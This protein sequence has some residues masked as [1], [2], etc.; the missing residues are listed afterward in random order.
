[1]GGL[2]DI[3]L[4]VNDRY[5]PTRSHRANPGRSTIQRED[6][7]GPE[8]YVGPITDR[9]LS[10]GP[11]PEPTDITLENFGRPIPEA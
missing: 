8:A 10:N 4:L 7:Q 11:G 5:P 1:L 6:E 2:R 9:S 3:A